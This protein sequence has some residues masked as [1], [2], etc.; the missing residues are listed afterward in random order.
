LDKSY[1]PHPLIYK[2][3]ETGLIFYVEG[4]GRH[5]TALTPE[6]K[7]LWRRDPFAD[8]KLGPYRYERPVIVYVGPEAKH[9]INGHTGRFIGISFNSSQFGVM[10]VGTGDFIFEGND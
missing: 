1:D 7:I 10:N 4:D 3:S 2:D 9:E 6:G 8:A 5:I